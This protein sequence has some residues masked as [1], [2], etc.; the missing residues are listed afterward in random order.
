MA[1][2]SASEK[3]SRFSGEIRQAIADSN[4]AFR[5]V[6]RYII[7]MGAQR[8]VKAVDDACPP[9]ISNSEAQDEQSIIHSHATLA[10]G[11]FLRMKGKINNVSPGAS[12]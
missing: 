1:G 12:L 7:P 5:K 8:I 3:W 11:A 10:D 6:S 4:S 2:V 9:G